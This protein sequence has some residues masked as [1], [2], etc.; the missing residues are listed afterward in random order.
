M[1]W[2]HSMPAHATMQAAQPNTAF[3]H[4]AMNKLLCKPLPLLQKE[5]NR[6]IVTSRSR[7]PCIHSP[8]PLTLPW[9]PSAAMLLQLVLLPLRECV[10]LPHYQH[11]LWSY[12]QHQP[13]L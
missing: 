10:L 6:K 3:T 12:R 5:T 1:V 11:H 13:Q 7:L 4:M 8:Q 2:K 9:I